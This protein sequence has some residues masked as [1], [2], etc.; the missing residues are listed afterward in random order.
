MKPLNP[1]TDTTHPVLR[2]RSFAI[3]SPPLREFE[4]KVYETV[5]AGEP[6][7]SAAGPQRAGK[8][9]TAHFLAKTIERQHTL[10]IGP[11]QVPRQQKSN[12][13][14]EHEF[15]AWMLASL[16]NDVMQATAGDTRK[17]L[18]NEI[19][20]RADRLE[21]RRVF[22]IFDE[23]QN[24]TVQHLALLKMMVD[25]LIGKGFSPFA[26]LIGQPELYSMVRRLLKPDRA[27]RKYVD[28]VDRFFTQ[29]YQFRGITPEELPLVLAAYDRMVFPAESSTTFSAHFAP[30]LVQDGWRLA[31]TANALETEFRRVFNQFQMGPMKELGMKYVTAAARILLLSLQRTGA[32]S[33][34]NITPNLIRHCVDRCGLIDV[35]QHGQG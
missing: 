18:F 15:W 8:T 16:K 10:V 3:D 6:S 22:L 31:N 23:A 1:I 9:T 34:Q 28:L 19:Y 5:E 20:I 25:V 33:L 12:D 27:G 4:V 30:K 35:A 11:I 32:S 2:P 14:D 17:V 24:L 13:I 29:R 21:N 26:L 7:L